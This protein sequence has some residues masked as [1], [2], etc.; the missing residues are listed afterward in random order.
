LAAYFNIKSAKTSAREKKYLY[1][2]E[3]QSRTKVLHYMNIAWL[4]NYII[5]GAV[6]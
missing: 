1:N 5:I 6:A 3:N 2:N 4:P